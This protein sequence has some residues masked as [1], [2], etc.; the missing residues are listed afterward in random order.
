MYSESLQE[1]NDDELQVLS[2]YWS[3]QLNRNAE[4]GNGSRELVSVRV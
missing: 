3:G 2:P 4:T 1:E